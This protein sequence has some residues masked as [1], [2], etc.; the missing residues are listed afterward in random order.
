MTLFAI[1]ATAVLLWAWFE[2]NSVGKWLAQIE[3]G[4]REYLARVKGGGNDIRD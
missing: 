3:D 2:P 4:K 1:F